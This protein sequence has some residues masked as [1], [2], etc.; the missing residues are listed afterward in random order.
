MSQVERVGFI[1]LGTMG[2]AMATNLLKAGFSVCG[3]DPVPG[4]AAALGSVGGRT[5]GSAAEAAADAELVIMMVPDVPEIEA[6]LDGDGGLLATPGNGRILMIMCTIDPAAVTA[7]AE[8]VTSQGWRYVDCPV[9]RTADDARNANST[10][11]LGGAP[12]DKQAVSP[13]LEAMGTTIIDCGDVGH[14]M[15]VKIV[16]NFLSTAGAVLVAE[17]LR[18]AESGGV[19]ADVALEVVNGTIAGNGHSKVHFPAKVLRG[20]VN[21]GFAIMHAR[22]DCAIAAKAI[23]RE[24]FPNFLAP[25]VVA[26]YDAA[27]ESGHGSNDWSDMFNVVNE[28]RRNG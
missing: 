5:A 23:E 28:L 2:H 19:N 18:L 13:A 4:A 26:A 1:G 21:P 7:I 14:G 8:R 17:A 27:L 11:M 25:A 22:K 16:N 24:G 15:T 3:Y 12:A 10:F 9:G 20:D 6:N